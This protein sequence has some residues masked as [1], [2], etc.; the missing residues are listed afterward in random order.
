MVNF[1]S[2]FSYNVK[3]L[4]YNVLYKY[5]GYKEKIDSFEWHIDKLL[6][7]NDLVRNKYLLEMFEHI[8]DKNYV[9]FF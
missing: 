3:K 6:R 2:Y 8:K 1:L 9:F 4:Y 7:Y 5:C